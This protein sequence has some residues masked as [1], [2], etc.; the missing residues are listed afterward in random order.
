MGSGNKFEVFI[1]ESWGFGINFS[2]FPHSLSVN[3]H[4]IKFGLYIGFGKGYD[5]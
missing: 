4:F 5:E 2:R 3:I 1:T